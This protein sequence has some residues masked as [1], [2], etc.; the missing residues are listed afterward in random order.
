MLREAVH[1]GGVSFE[2]FLYADLYLREQDPFGRRRVRAPAP[3][4]LMFQSPETDLW[5]PLS[6]A[7]ALDNSGSI[8][9]TT[10]TQITASFTITGSNTVIL[11]FV[12]CVAG[13]DPVT[14]VKQNGVSLTLIDAVVPGG[15]QR[16]CSSWGLVGATSGTFE[17][18]ASPIGILM[19]AFVSYTGVKQTGLPD[20]HTTNNTGTG[21]ATSQTTTV[22]TVA[23]DCWAVLGVGNSVGTITASTGYTSRQN[24]SSGIACGD[25]NGLITPAGGYS[26]TVTG[27]ARSWVNMG[28]SIAPAST[29][30]RSLASLGVG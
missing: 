18:N 14:S 11:A 22:T 1:D 7:I 23:D 4:A 15:T 29:G 10:A 21:T 13:V 8:S 5:L 25:S 27:T 26:L 17:V 20:S 24:N 16:D 2:S 28:V 30:A 3:H 6:L 9:A 19:A 12:R